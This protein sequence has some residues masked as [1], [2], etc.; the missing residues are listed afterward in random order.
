MTEHKRYPGM[1][2]Y[3]IGVIKFVEQ[4]MASKGFDT[5]GDELCI[6]CRL[7]SSVDNL[8]KCN[9]DVRITTEGNDLLVDVGDIKPTVVFWAALGHAVLNPFWH[10]S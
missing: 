5:Y 7:K 1:A 10:G 4:Y 9:V 3:K 6:H 2:I 8:T